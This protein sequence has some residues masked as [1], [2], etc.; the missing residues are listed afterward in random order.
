MKKKNEEAVDLQGYEPEK[1][2]CGVKKGKRKCLSD[3]RNQNPEGFD[4]ERSW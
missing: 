1:K 4:M 2:V 3:E